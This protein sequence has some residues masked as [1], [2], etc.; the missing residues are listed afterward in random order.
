MN[1]YIRFAYGR[2]A[3]TQNSVIYRPR[4]AQTCSGESYSGYNGRFAL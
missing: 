2:M 1:E 4:K 3:Y